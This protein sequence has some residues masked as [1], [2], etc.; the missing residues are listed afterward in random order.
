MFE[1][2]VAAIEQKLLSEAEFLLARIEAVS[3]RLETLSDVK[4]LMLLVDQVS[5]NVTALTGELTLETD[6]SRDRNIEAEYLLSKPHVLTNKAR[7]AIHR[8][9]LKLA[10]RIRETLNPPKDEEISF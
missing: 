4:A 3:G 6:Q 7:T 10:L 9:M 8:E 2:T 1:F 5:D